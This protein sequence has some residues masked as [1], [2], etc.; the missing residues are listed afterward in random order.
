MTPASRDEL[1]AIQRHDL[2]SFIAGAFT[3]LHPEQN[4][5]HNWHIDVISDRLEG[6]RTGRIKRL[7][8]TVP[9]RS[10][11]SIAVSVG[12]VAYVLGHDPTKKII[13]ASYGQDLS[14][15][16]ARDTLTV[17][18]SPW[19]TGLFGNILKRSVTADFETTKR[20]GRMATSVGGVLTGRGA[21]IL[22]V[23]DPTK[24]DEAAS[25][26]AREKANQWYDETLYSRLNDKTTGAII[27]IMQRLH[28]DDL[29]GHVLEKGD[30]EIVNLPAVA[31]TEET[32]RYSVFGMPQEYVR[33]EGEALHP[34]REPLE[35]LAEIEKNQGTFVYSAQYLQAPVPSGGALV[36]A[37]W[38]AYYRPEELPAFD[39]VIQS[40]DTAS[41]ITQTADYSV[42]TTWGVK[43][44][45]TYLLHVFR[46]RLEYPELRRKVK[47]LA[48]KF[49]ARTILIEEKNSGVQL[50]QELRRD[51]V[52][53]VR[54]FTPSSEK[55]AR[56][57]AQTA[58]IE[59]GHVLFPK[60]APWLDAYIN[61]LLAFP[62]TKKDDQVDSTS[63]AL[64]YIATVGAEPAMLAYMRDV[65]EARARGEYVPGWG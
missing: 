39:T 53:G 5:L 7:I 14:N 19:Y 42:G 25:D 21:D 26:S 4:Y 40:W 20:G 31:Q 2:S 37:S 9:P 61:E 33:K 65:C 49:H 13:C 62:F 60:E 1:R 43:R 63:Q 24:P 11:K 48:D 41:K 51:G 3:Q 50:I 22:I 56:M 45:K 12:F 36:K 27:L 23:D 30:W 58:Q 55:Y 17:M 34:A 44:D 64:E 32:W 57:S 47:E 28:L 8:I 38:L 16:L 54:A 46:G 59:S 10:L 15:K 18:Q 29:V 6:V 52:G 35:S